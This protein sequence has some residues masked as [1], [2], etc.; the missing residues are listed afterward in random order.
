VIVSGTV[1]PQYVRIRR[2][3]GPTDAGCAASSYYY[4]PDGCYE[5][6]PVGGEQGSVQAPPVVGGKGGGAGGG[7]EESAG[8]P[9][10][11]PLPQT[12]TNAPPPPAPP[13]ESGGGP[14]VPQVLHKEKMPA[15]GLVP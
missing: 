1:K 9:G 10:A 8:G 2:A 15:T 5:V 11:P 13:S 7:G 4:C 3:C 12:T 6:T 14:Q